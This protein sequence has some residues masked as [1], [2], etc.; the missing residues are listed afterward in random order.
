M[1]CLSREVYHTWRSLH[2]GEPESIQILGSYLTQLQMSYC[3]TNIHSL[4]IFRLPKNIQHQYINIHVHSAIIQLE[5]NHSLPL[6]IK[7]KIIVYY[8]PFEGKS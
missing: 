8:H 5:E 3:P 2:Y 6:S 1:K 7:R 4:Q